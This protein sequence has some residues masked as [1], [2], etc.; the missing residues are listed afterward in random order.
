MIVSL[1]PLP[2][3]FAIPDRVGERQREDARD[4]G[5]RP[6]L[7]EIDRDPVGAWEKSSV[8]VAAVLGFD[9]RLAAARAA[10]ERECVGAAAA[11]QRVIARATDQG[12]GAARADQRVVA[13][14]ALKEARCPRSPRRRA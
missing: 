4:H 10:V 6:A 11:D 8:R 13:R 1:Y 2:R 5:L 3:T 12:V 9:H 7:V 14:A